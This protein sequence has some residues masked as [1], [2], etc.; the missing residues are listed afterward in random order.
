MST[1]LKDKRPTELSQLNGS[2][3]EIVNL[4]KQFLRRI[5]DNIRLKNIHELLNVSSE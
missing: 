4:Q 1:S 3:I 2:N 5:K